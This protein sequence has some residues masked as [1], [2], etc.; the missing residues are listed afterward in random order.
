MGS[1]GHGGGSFR[2]DALGRSAVEGEPGRYVQVL[3]APLRVH[4]RRRLRR[5]FLSSRAH[6]APA[7]NQRTR[8][9]LGLPGSSLLRRQDS[10]L[11]VVGPTAGA[12]GA[13]RILP[14]LPINEAG[15]SMGNQPRLVSR[16]QAS[17]LL[18][19]AQRLAPLA[20]F[21][22]CSGSWS[23]TPV[24]AGSPASFA[25]LRAAFELARALAQLLA[26]LA[27]VGPRSRRRFREEAER[28]AR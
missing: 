5:P 19:M 27:C 1:L 12:V 6:E 2:S 24:V 25:R 20:R 4:S 16:R 13:V 21:E 10:T 8:T 14:P 22:S 3:L 17:N 7:T 28:T 15:R 11:P 26:P 23:P 18:S 9:A